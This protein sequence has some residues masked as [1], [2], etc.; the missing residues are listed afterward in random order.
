MV[1]MNG[2]REIYLAADAAYKLFDAAIQKA[3]NGLHQRSSISHGLRQS[4]QDHV[5]SDVTDEGPSDN[6]PTASVFPFDF[7]QATFADT[8]DGLN[9]FNVL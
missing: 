5:V 4:E 1:A 3:N 6:D 8:A 7:W 2:L 9:D